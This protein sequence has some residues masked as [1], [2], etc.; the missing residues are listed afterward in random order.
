MAKAAVPENLLPDILRRIREVVAPKKVILFGSAARGE[1][2]ANSDLDLLV[3][4]PPGLHRRRT[5]QAIYQ[6]LIGV[7]FAVD[8]IV[9]TEE[10]VALY[11]EDLGMIIKPALEEG[12]LLYAA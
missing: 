1:M 5:A 6:N 4:V 10:D 11:R 3:I 8:I 9:V 12:K 7:G 2:S